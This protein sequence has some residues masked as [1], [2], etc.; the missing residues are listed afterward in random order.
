[1]EP[2]FESNYVLTHRDF[3]QAIAN[4]YRAKGTLKGHFIGSVIM[5]WLYD[6]NY[7]L[8]LLDEATVIDTWKTAANYDD[9]LLT[10]MINAKFIIKQCKALYEKNKDE[11]KADLGGKNPEYVC[12][13]TPEYY[14]A[15]GMAV[16]P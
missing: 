3:W 13:L 9:Y 7:A 4:Q 6:V 10:S 5:N 16:E 2:E 14:F 1:M 12:D 15:T 11:I 8:D